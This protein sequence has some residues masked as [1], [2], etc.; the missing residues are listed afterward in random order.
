MADETEDLRARLLANR[1]E[2]RAHH[3]ALKANM[4][5]GVRLRQ[6]AMRTSAERLRDVAQRVLDGQVAAE[7]S[8]P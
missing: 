7:Q 2:R 4:T 3:E 6:E 1:E 8:R 5:E